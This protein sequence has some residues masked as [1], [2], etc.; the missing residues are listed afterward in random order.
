[1]SGMVGLKIGWLGSFS[2]DKSSLYGGKAYEMQ[3]LRFLA[4]NYEVE[5]VYPHDSKKNELLRWAAELYRLSKLNV[6][7]DVV[8]RDFYSSAVMGR[9]S[10][11]NISIIHH[12]DSS[13]KNHPLLNRLLEKKFYMNLNRIDT[14]V[15]VSEFWKRCIE[16]MGH[17]DVRVVYNGFD[18][19]EFEIAREEVERFRE[20]YR[21]CGKP[22][23]YLGNCQP[24]K[25]VV[26]AYRELK[27][28]DAF[29]VTS[30]EKQVNIPAK[31]LNLDY[32]DYLILLKASSVVVAMSKF[33]EGWNRTAHEA[34]L[35]KTP[36][37]GSGLGGMR[38]LLEGGK[39][40]L[41]EELSAL[42]DLVDVAVANGAELGEYGCEFAKAF[43][44]ERFEQGWRRILRA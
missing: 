14:I 25:G 34:M 29:L 12:I 32:K 20:K 11:R 19:K 43:T 16:E 36:V 22:I 5:E 1:M 28:R 6:S 15:T 8:I 24:A 7:K 40:L 27:D 42:N 21:L 17:D 3:L 4:D 26:E 41:C 44:I 37:I 23:I 18:V 13:Q 39:Q 30:G 33:K 9:T 31:N 38:E 10:G 2:R 35:C